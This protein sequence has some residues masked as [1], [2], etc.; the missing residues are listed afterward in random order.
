MSDTSFELDEDV[1]GILWVS[2]AID[3]QL[4]LINT[5]KLFAKDLHMFFCILIEREEVLVKLFIGAATWWDLDL[6]SKVVSLLIDT[7][8]IGVKD[9]LTIWFV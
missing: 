2:I 8:F 4:L 1:S 5:E 6:S 3:I 7:P 9:K